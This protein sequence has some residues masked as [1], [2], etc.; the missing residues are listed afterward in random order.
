[1]KNM[2]IDNTLLWQANAYAF[3]S[4]AK[5]IIKN[6]QKQKVSALELLKKIEEQI[7]KPEKQTVET[8]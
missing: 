2:R 7:I 4:Q 3:K 5:E 8:E 6:L 1:M